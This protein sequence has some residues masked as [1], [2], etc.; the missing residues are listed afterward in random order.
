M[1]KSFVLHPFLFALLPIIFLYSLNVGEVFAHEIIQ[2]ILLAIFIT[3]VIWIALSFVLKSKIKSGFITS[4]GLII[5][6]YYG[7]IFIQLERQLELDVNHLHY[8]LLITSFV[9]LGLGSYYIIKTKKHLD[10]LTMIVNVIA[11]AMVMVSFVNIGEFYLLENYSLNIQDE[12]SEKIPIEKLNTENF[13]DIYYIMFDGYAGSKS[14]QYLMNF[15]NSEFIDF[16]TK[17]G[18]YVSPESYS[19]YED[20][21]FSIP[22]TLNMKYLNYLVE[23]VGINSTNK[24]ILYPILY[25]NEVAQYLK[26]KGYTIFNIESG[27]VFSTGFKHTDFPLCQLSN[28]FE[29]EFEMMLIRTSMINPIHV[30]LFSGDWRDRILCG[31]NELDKVVDRNEKPKLVYANFLMP[32]PPYI[33]NENCGVENAKSLSLAEQKHRVGHDLYLGQLK[34]ANNKIKPILRN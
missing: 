1:K 16:L 10:K 4:L 3:F 30:Q 23:E 14:L 29:S 13:P 21:L 15:D 32:H 27:L 20:T 22:S 34:C 31:F 5:F 12:S 19:N 2:P 28:Y 7:H 11:I 24:L 33:F 6:F 9:L 17:K 18:F 26:S 25:D 8:I